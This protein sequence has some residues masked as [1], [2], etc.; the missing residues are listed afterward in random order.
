MRKV[1]LRLHRLAV[2]PKIRQIILELTHPGLLSLINSLRSEKVYSDCFC[3]HSHRFY[4]VEN[5]QKF[6][7]C[8]SS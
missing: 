1:L 5:F 8:H 3:Q 7:L 4:N 6:L 2:L